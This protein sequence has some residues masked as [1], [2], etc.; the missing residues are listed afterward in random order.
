MNEKFS[1]GIGIPKTLSTRELRRVARGV[2]S[3]VRRHRQFRNSLADTD[4][5]SWY[6]FLDVSQDDPHFFSSYDL[7]NALTA[8][9]LGAVQG[10]LSVLAEL[11]QLGDMLVYEE[12]L[13]KRS[14][15]MELTLLETFLERCPSGYQLQALSNVEA[16]T[17]AF[18]VA[19]EIVAFDA[20]WRPSGRL[21]TVNRSKYRRAEMQIRAL[22]S[23]GTPGLRVREGQ[24]LGDWRAAVRQGS[25]LARAL[26]REIGGVLII[27][28]V[29]SLL[30]R[31]ERSG[32]YLTR[33]HDVLIRDP[34]L[35]DIP[36][37]YLLDLAAQAVSVTQLEL[38]EPWDG[39]REKLWTRLLRVLRN[40][41]AVY[42]VQFY[43]G[44]EGLLFHDLAGFARDVVLYD[45]L[46]TIPQW[47]P[48]DLP[49]LITAAFGWLPDEFQA[50][51]GF[52]VRDAAVFAGRLLDW[53]SQR[54]GVPLM[55]S[56]EMAR[57]RCPEL[58]DVAFAALL[59]A[60]SLPADRVNQGLHDP[61]SRPNA[62]HSFALRPLVEESG[63]YV[64]FAAPW[65]AQAFFEVVG[66][67]ALRWGAQHPEVG[68]RQK[69]GDAIEL[70]VREQL[71]AHNVRAVGGKAQNV[72]GNVECDAVVETADLRVFIEVKSK[73]LTWA[74]RTGQDVYL[75]RDFANSGVYAAAQ[76]VRNA[77]AVIRHG[78]MLLVDADGHEAE[79]IDRGEDV[80]TL[81]LSLGEFGGLQTTAAFQ[82]ALVVMAAGGEFTAS[83]SLDDEERQAL[84]DANKRAR[85]YRRAYEKLVEVD[86]AVAEERHGRRLFLSIAQ[87][88]VLLDGVSDAQQFANRLLELSVWAPIS[89]DPYVP[90]LKADGTRRPDFITT[91]LLA[92]T[93]QM[94]ALK[95]PLH[96]LGRR[97]VQPE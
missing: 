25:E 46:F 6:R 80:I 87:F 86:P 65:R 54:E 28:R 42:N 52:S 15:E 30:E 18:E 32:R 2:M 11:R 23:L 29:F 12:Q 49:R 1:G 63:Q 22:L 60:A 50:T 39:R 93:G 72:P 13:Q 92:G 34:R 62:E 45:H 40:L 59:D 71:A 19:S 97:K 43:N 51:S 61:D 89:L 95:G 10:E 76:A 9:M 38:A 26:I 91:A 48:S 7:S 37:S 67:A 68:I 96:S 70:F 55:F 44:F 73:V 47:R 56:A 58:S 90:I 81:S 14:V 57:R 27:Q 3:V 94:F 64:F 5:S 17:R 24:L 8:R 78:R 21:L 79:V 75:L 83:R 69:L 74:G 82:E 4:F 88:L 85:Q 31:D 35:P 84:E 77:A 53:Q 66:S 16:W 36:W 20:A 41:A 33:R